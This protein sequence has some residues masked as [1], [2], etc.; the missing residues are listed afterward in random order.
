MQG[1]IFVKIVEQFLNLWVQ[2]P[3]ISA[4]MV[5]NLLHYAILARSQAT[6]SFILFVMEDA[7][8][9]FFLRCQGLSIVKFHHQLFHSIVFIFF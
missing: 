7:E 5:F 3:P 1:L 2:T 9:L 8:L 4:H 6:N